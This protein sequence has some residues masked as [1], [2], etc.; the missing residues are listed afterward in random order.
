M[1]NPAEI[2]ETLEYRRRVEA[3]Y[4]QLSEAELIAFIRNHAPG[5]GHDRAVYILHGIMNQ[6]VLVANAKVEKLKL[7][8]VGS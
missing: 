2:A 8:E 5:V 6:I 3:A 7:S 4:A 1:N